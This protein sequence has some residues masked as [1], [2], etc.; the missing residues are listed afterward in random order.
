MMKVG[1]IDFGD[2]SYYLDRKL[3]TLRLLSKMLNTSMFRTFAVLLY[4]SEK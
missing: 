1:R 2:A 4:G 3:L